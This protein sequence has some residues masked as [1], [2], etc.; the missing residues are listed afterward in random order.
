M[1]LNDDSAESLPGNS[2]QFF[3]QKGFGYGQKGQIC[4]SRCRRIGPKRSKTLD[5]GNRLLVASSASDEKVDGFLGMDDR[6]AGN[7]F[8]EALARKF[9]DARM[10]A[11]MIDL[12]PG[13]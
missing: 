6:L 10:A 8:P 1:R 3:C 11:E 9:Y 7:S 13:Q 4:G 2:L 5:F 12:S